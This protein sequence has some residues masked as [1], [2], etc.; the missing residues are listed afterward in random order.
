VTKGQRGQ[1]RDDRS[2]SLPKQGAKA[3][4]DG[5]KSYRDSN[6]F[7]KA[8]SW[9][10]TRLW[11]VFLKRRKMVTNLPPQ[12]YELLL[13]VRTISPGREG[14]AARYAD[15]FLPARCSV[16]SRAMSEERDILVKAPLWIVIKPRSVPDCQAKNIAHSR[17]KDEKLAVKSACSKIICSER[18]DKPEE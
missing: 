17:R 3:V 5:F 9:S 7:K 18:G 2:R 8:N 16:L 11:V 1:V 13:V 15:P 10:V 6:I 12:F 4:S 14:I